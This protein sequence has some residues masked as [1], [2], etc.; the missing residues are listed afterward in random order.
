MS[1]KDSGF[2]SFNAA[3]IGIDY[4]NIIDKLS[5]I[6]SP[7]DPIRPVAII[8]GRP[9]N[10]VIKEDILPNLSEY[11]LRS[12]EFLEI[13]CVGFLE[14]E[15]EFRSV[16]P[17]DAHAFLR[18]TDSFED[19]TKWRYSGETDLLLMNSYWQPKRKRAVLDF[20]TVICFT[21]ERALETK[22]IKS[23]PSFIQDLLT[24]AKLYRG[25][26]LPFD[27][28]DRMS[29]RNLGGILKAIFFAIIP[30]PFKDMAKGEPIEK[31][32][33]WITKDFTTA[34]LELLARHT[35][36]EKIPELEE[37]MDEKTRERF[38][39]L[40]QA[41]EESTPDQKA[42]DTLLLNLRAAEKKS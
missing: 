1:E 20:T 14:A 9:H 28:S 16:D 22:V 12:G 38:I 19:K 13:F 11:H 37:M 7:E 27:Y 25:D 35:E 34:E 42:F 4:D 41:V 32:T 2:G 8:F 6:L 39:K 21:L 26:N 5:S 24:Y 36:K 10:K 33:S 29:I 18:A 30:P 31:S 17:F 15:G 23:V 3:H 40:Q